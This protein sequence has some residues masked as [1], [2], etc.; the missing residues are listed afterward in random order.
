MGDTTPLK[1]LATADNKPASL[2]P[3]NNTP[4]KVKVTKVTI[5]K[6]KKLKVPKEKVPRIRKKIHSQAKASAGMLHPPATPGYQAPDY[7]GWNHQ[8]PHNMPWNKLWNSEL[9][10]ASFGP[11]FPQNGYGDSS[12]S[13]AATNQGFDPSGHDYVPG[14]NYAG[15]G[16]APHNGFYGHYPA[17]NGYAPLINKEDGWPEEKLKLEPFSV[18]VII[19]FSSFHNFCEGSPPKKAFI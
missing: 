18:S 2:P 6:A 19:F 9:H 15:Q 7:R 5:P 13:Y 17:A 1:Q 12:H 16:Y 14:Y 3:F 4:K 11:V 10:D 8:S